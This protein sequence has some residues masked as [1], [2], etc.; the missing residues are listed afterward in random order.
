M[1]G[2]VHDLS[3]AGNLRRQEVSMHTDRDK[4]SINESCPF[5]HDYMPNNNY[6]REYA[7]PTALKGKVDHLGS[8]K[9]LTLT[10]FIM[11]WCRVR[12][13]QMID[14]LKAISLMQISGPIMSKR[15]FILDQIATVNICR[16]QLH[17][18]T[19]IITVNA[20]DN[21]LELIQ[22]INQNLPV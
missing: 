8:D 16:I 22:I 12:W 9:E 14:Y 6:H 1:E 21:I 18:F 4:L 2:T 19:T 17:T 15:D 7:G 3:R 10:K 5:W 13:P 20:I 11:V